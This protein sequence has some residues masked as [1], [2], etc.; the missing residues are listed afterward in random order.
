MRNNIN[1]IGHMNGNAD[2]NYEI[3]FNNALL[4]SKK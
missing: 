1:H 3:N 4:M 2:D